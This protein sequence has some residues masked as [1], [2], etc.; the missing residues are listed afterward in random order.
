MKR[1]GRLVAVA[2]LAVSSGSWAGEPTSFLSPETKILLGPVSGR[3]DHLAI[4]LKRKRLFVAELGNDSV[5]VVDLGAGKTERTLAGLRE[6]QGVGYE[7]TTDTLHVANAAD[8]SVRLFQGPDL[9][10]AGAVE[11]GDDADNVRID[12]RTRR[13]F[14]GY[15]R[16]ALAII[17]PANRTKVGNIPLAGHPESFQLDPDNGRAFVNV[18]DARQVAVVDLASGRQAATW[19]FSH[20]QANFPMAF[21]IAAKQVLVGYR[22]PARLVAFDVTDGRIA[23]ALDLCDD[24]D[25][26]FVDAKRHRLYA[27][28]G[29][30]VVD[31]FEWQ[32]DRYVRVGHVSTASGARTSLF[33]PE[34]DRLFVAERATFREPAAIQVLRPA[35]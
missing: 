27:S 35:P 14:V 2:S 30:G 26:L 9:I 4:D 33:V 17:D 19:H 6:P 11:L 7:L 5:G 21:D 34:L 22:R 10:P 18:P 29:E 13:V 32:A 3:I 25:D 8:G 31:V 12:V 1:I 15:G 20:A 28:C 24:A 16:G 23:A